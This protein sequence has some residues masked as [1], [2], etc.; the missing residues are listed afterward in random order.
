MLVVI[1]GKEIFLIFQVIFVIDLRILKLIFGHILKHFH[2]LRMVVIQNK[3]IFLASQTQIRILSALFKINFRRICIRLLHS[4]RIFRNFRMVCA[5][6]NLISIK[7]SCIK[8]KSGSEKVLYFFNTFTQLCYFSIIL[9]NFRNLVI[10]IS[11]KQVVYRL[12][13]FIMAIQIYI[14]IRFKTASLGVIIVP[15]FSN[16]LLVNIL[17]LLALDMQILKSVL[18]L[19]IAFISRR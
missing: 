4:T 16:I 2:F 9:T 19:I 17:K 7:F 8:V 11:I 3:D 10:F 5:K 12:L 1:F 18:I 14:I 13:R 6:I 15:T